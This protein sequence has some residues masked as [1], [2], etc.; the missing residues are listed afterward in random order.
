MVTKINLADK[1][2]RFTD[3]W[4][5]KIVADDELF[6][7]VRGEL[8]IE[9]R[10]GQVT[11][12]PGE[13]VVIPKGVEH[14]PVAR[15]EVHTLAACRLPPD[16]ALPAWAPAPAP[17]LTI[18]RTSEELSITTVQR[19][20][21]PTVRCERDYRALRVRGTLPPDLVGILVSIAEPLARAGLSLFA[22]ST[23][24]TDYVLVKARD[25]GRGPGGLAKGRSQSECLR[26]G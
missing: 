6:M 16:A 25:L 9:L 11:L 20:V 10:D 8:T 5:P 3:Q 4:S 17:F 26:V 12:R 1:F 2:D 22:I 7:V 18:S 15:E 21:P 19:A 23:Y 24:D 14:R 13:M